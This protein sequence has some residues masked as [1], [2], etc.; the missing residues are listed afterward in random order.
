LAEIIEVIN[1]NREIYLSQNNNSNLCQAIVEVLFWM[2]LPNDIEKYNEDF[3][4]IR[5][6]LKM[7]CK[8]E[9]G[10]T[11]NLAVNCFRTMC[12]IFL[13]NDRKEDPSS[14]LII[15]F[16]VVE[17]KLWKNHM[18]SAVDQIMS[19]ISDEQKIVEMLSLF[20]KWIVQ[21]P[22]TN[23]NYLSMW[24]TSFINSLEQNHKQYQMTKD[25]A[26]LVLP[27]IFSEHLN[28]DIFYSIDIQRNIILHLMNRIESLEL[29]HKIMPKIF[30]LLSTLKSSISDSNNLNVMCAITQIIKYLLKK[31]SEHLK[32]SC[33]ICREV[34]KLVLNDNSQINNSQ[35]SEESEEMEVSYPSTSNGFG[36]FNNVKVGLLNLGNT[37]YMN[38]VLQALA[39]TSQFCHEVLLYKTKNELSNETVL[40]NLQNLFAL[41][42]YT[43][44]NSLSPTAILYASKPSYFMP[45]HQQDSSEF[46]WL[47]HNIL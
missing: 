19:E 8:R 16:Q 25:I 15:V 31:F 10:I 17:E 14:A 47:V 29:F 6:F 2:K 35:I 21:C 24:L 9:S 40:K 23:M 7:I 11:K 5:D 13:K 27:S 12:T 34:K 1:D 32:E 28:L 18:D 37:C 36:R 26:E 45:G 33:S 38:G 41:L 39:M 43:E 22:N 4:K 46:L 3:R 20:C 42:K 44:T 30:I